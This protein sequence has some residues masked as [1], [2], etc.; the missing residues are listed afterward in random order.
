MRWLAMAKNIKEVKKEKKFSFKKVMEVLKKIFNNPKII[1]IA[2]S[3]ICIILL[4]A[5]VKGNK[6]EAF[7]FGDSQTSDLTIQDIHYFT[8][9]KINYFYSSGAIFSGDDKQ[10]YA[11]KVGYY[12]VDKNNNYIEFATYANVLSNAVSLKDIVAINSAFSVAEYTGNA[13]LFT[14]DVL[15]NMNNL[16]FVIQASTVKDADTYDVYL[17]YPIN[18]KEVIS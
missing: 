11:Y 18:V 6:K 9:K 10:I 4:I 13:S 5:L 14:S 12:V 8:N 2:L 7:Y 15:A 17:D 3:I 1:I 16:H